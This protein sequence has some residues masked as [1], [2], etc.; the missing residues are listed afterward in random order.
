MRLNIETHTLLPKSVG[1]VLNCAS[2][3]LNGGTV[4]DGSPYVGVSAM[5]P[6]YAPRVRQRPRPH[7]R[8][9][10]GHKGGG[11]NRT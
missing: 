6:S 11:A 3:H 1:E 10:G 5:F 8:A 4:A 9:H 7:Y 2:Y